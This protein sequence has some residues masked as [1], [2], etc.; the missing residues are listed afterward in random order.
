MQ[1][2]TVLITGSTD[3]IGK[4][5]AQ[6]LARMGAR[7][8]LH[9]RNQERGEIAREEIIKSTGNHQVEFVMADLGSQEQVRDLAAQVHG[10]TDQ[11]NVL[12]NNAGVDLTERQ[13]TEDGYEMTFAVNYL[14]PFLLT[15]LLMD[16][17]QNGKPSRI[18]NVSSS[19]H[20]K[21][22]IDFENLQG[23]KS[24][25]GWH[26]YTT[27]K[28]ALVM[29]TKEL[30]ERLESSGITCNC[31]HPGAVDTKMLRARFPDFKGISL[32]AGAATSVYLASSPDVETISGEYFDACK[33]APYSPLADDRELRKRLWELSERLTQCQWN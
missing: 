18:I 22:R 8:L 23:E 14:A 9:G 21:A 26:A 3:G 10:L 20:V 17:I 6:E 24:F 33:I 32:Q 1:D 30:A 2:K 4:Q 11:I 31:L 28:L 27:T 19:V 16:L 25:I 15:N 29:F 13:L 12:I 5:A 7:I